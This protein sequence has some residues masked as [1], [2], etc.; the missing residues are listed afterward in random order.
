MHRKRVVP[1]M[2]LR[3]TGPA[4]SNPWIVRAR[5]AAKAVERARARRKE[6]RARARRVVSAVGPAQVAA[7][8]ARF[9][10]TSRTVATTISW[11]GR[12]ARPRS[13][14]RTRSCARHSGKNTGDTR[15]A[16]EASP[17]GESA[18]N[19]L[20]SLWIALPAVALVATGCVVKETRPLPLLQATQATAEIP[21]EQLLDVGIHI[22][23]PGIPKE[24]EEDPDLADK[25]RVYPDIRKAEARY[26]AM[27][28]RDTLE[29]TGHWGAARV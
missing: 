9:R 18:M 25:T 26:V 8:R 23:D 21:E 29:G 17:M 11:R 28:L 12:S 3:A 22:F 24:V 10:L 7:A 27:Q 1:T 14:K 15:K 6:R 16:V 2:P 4:D 20:T 13:R 19:R 5:A